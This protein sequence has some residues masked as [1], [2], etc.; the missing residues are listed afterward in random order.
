MGG[1]APTRVVAHP[2]LGH[3]PGHNGIR[4]DGDEREPGGHEHPV[5]QPETRQPPPRLEPRDRRRCHPD[6]ARQLALAQVADAARPHDEPSDR[7]RVGPL[8]TLDIFDTVHAR[9]LAPATDSA[10]PHDT[11]H[12]H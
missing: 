4:V 9:T 5:E 12:P 6:P 3:R 7:R 2:T 1:K 8:D 10:A 11:A